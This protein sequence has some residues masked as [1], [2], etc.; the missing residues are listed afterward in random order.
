MPHKRLKDG[1]S[2]LSTGG[3]QLL[4]L[5]EGGIGV[6][7]MLDWDICWEEAAVTLGTG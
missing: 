2:H 6:K 7:W 3:R 4:G 5:I 1:A